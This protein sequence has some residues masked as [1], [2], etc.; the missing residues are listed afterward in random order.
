MASGKTPGNAYISIADC[1]TCKKLPQK[2]A[3]NYK[4]EN[5]NIPPEIGKLV[6]IIEFEDDNTPA[7]CTSTTRLLKCASCGSLYYYNHY[8]DEGQHFMDPTFDE[9]TIRRYNPLTAKR[10]LERIVG[11]S[12]GFM[13]NATGQ[14]MRAFVD[15]TSA[16]APGITIK[17]NGLESASK[18]LHDLGELF[19]GVIND[20]I[21]AIKTRS[22]DWQ[23]K[24]Y[25]IETLCAH[26]FNTGD[27]DALSTLLLDHEDPVVKVET[28]LHVIGMAT[29]DAPVIDIIHV[30]G[31][32]RAALKKQLSNKA[33]MRKLAE[34][35]LDVATSDE[36]RKT[37]AYDH[38]YGTSRYC[39]K[40]LQIA[41]LYGLV[42]SAEHVDLSSFIPAIIPLLKGNNLSRDACWVLKTIAR[43][44]STSAQHV[45][46]EVNAM[47]E[48][49][50]LDLSKDPEIKKLVDECQA[51]LKNKKSR[52]SHQH[53]KK[54]YLIG[55]WPSYICKQ[56][57]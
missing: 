52:T 35:L 6:V 27:L 50:N 16:Q 45:L 54:N 37:M 29:G 56:K 15:G 3:H 28:A 8:D 11:T 42:V 34:V 22:L 46:D 48:T 9:V 20:L 18:E 44:K 10:F 24:M 30:P 38:G 4:S 17:P 36:T 26:F 32:E 13:P 1:E 53:P 12:S 39:E 21:S 31:P 5:N 19:D 57:N 23:V 14:L 2:I 51:L 49:R 43:R 41:A 55:S 33:Y 25:I 7:Y 47:C 40:S